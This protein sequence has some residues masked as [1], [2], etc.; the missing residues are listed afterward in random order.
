MIASA[1]RPG[2]A[3]GSTRGI[4]ES[5]PRIESAPVTRASVKRTIQF[6]GTESAALTRATGPVAQVVRAHA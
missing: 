4:L 6:P 3:L 5:K 1:S 2:I